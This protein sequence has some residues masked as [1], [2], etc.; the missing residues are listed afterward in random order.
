MDLIFQAPMQYCSYSTDLYFHHQSHLQPGVFCLCLFILSGVTSP[1]FY[2]SIL[3]TYWPGNFIFQ[4]HIFLPFH[5]VQ[6]LSLEASG[7]WLQNLHRTREAD[8]WRA[9]T[10]P[11]VHQDPGEKSSDPTALTYSFSHLEPVCCSM[12]SSNFCFLTCIQISQEAGKMV[13]YSHFLKN[14]T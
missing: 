13:W 8:S 2:S 4:H 14:F 3:A 1:L 10:K 12:S 11:C 9:Q 5:T 6:N 7:I